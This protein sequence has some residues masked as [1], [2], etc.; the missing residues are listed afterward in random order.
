MSSAGLATFLLVYT[1]MW[2]IW[3]QTC[4]KQVSLGPVTRLQ[5]MRMALLDDAREAM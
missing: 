5:P 1:S 3:C 2:R 4:P